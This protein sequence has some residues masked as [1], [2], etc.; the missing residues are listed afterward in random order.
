MWQVDVP[1]PDRFTVDV[2]VPELI[3]INA[4][5][6]VALAAWLKLCQGEDAVPELLSLP[7]AE[8]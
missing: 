4:Q 8:T 7:V 5:A 2:Q 3:R 6:G 1:L